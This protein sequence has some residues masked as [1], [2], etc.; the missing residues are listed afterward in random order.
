MLGCTHLKID[1]LVKK[2]PL[3]VSIALSN[4]LT[5]YLWFFFFSDLGYASDCNNLELHDLKAVDFQ[6]DLP[7]NRRQEQ[8]FVVCV[9]YST[10]EDI[11]KRARALTYELPTGPLVPRLI[12]CPNEMNFNP[13][14][15]MCEN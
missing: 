4:D 11:Q 14:T 13:E 12:G 8:Y 7:E 6:I 10:D 5:K 1:R 2:F 3:T 15:K 9:P